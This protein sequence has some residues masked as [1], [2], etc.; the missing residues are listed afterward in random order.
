MSVLYA[1]AE[2][3]RPTLPLDLDTMASGIVVEGYEKLKE[4]LGI[5]SRTEMMNRMLRIVKPDEQVLQ[6]LDIDTRGIYRTTDTKSTGGDASVKGGTDDL[7]P[8][9]YTDI[10]GVER[11][12]PE[13]SY[14]FDQVSFPLSGDIAVSDIA[15]YPWPDPDNPVFVEGLQERIDWIRENTECANVLMLPVPIITN[16]QFLRGVEDWYMD[17][18]LNTK[19]LEALFDA[20]LEVNMQIAK[21]VLET[22]GKEVD[23]ACSCRNSPLGVR[24]STYTGQRKIYDTPPSPLLEPLQLIHNK[25]FVCED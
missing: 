2:G 18:I 5:E 13:G 19:V 9:K 15:N 21:N 10:W 6:A 23:V 20:L 11:I 17:F 25:G 16:S 14:Y 1:V 24:V 12:H 7:E 22:V 4:H 3:C 8:R